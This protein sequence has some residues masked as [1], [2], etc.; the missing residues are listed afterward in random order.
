PA[1][2]LYLLNRGNL[3]NLAPGIAYFGA[4]QFDPFAALM[5]A[6]FEWL[7]DGGAEGVAPGLHPLPPA[8][9]RAVAEAALAA[10]AGR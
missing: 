9:E 8:L 3:L 10:R 5:I 6:A 1:G 4:D 7:L 2:T